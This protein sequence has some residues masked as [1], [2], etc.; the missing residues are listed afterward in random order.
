MLQ[1]TTTAT[2]LLLLLSIAH[3]LQQQQQQRGY[4]SRLASHLTSNDADANSRIDDSSRRKFFVS[5][6]SSSLALVLLTNSGAANAD[7]AG[8]VDRTTLLS[9]IAKNAPDDV[10]IDII[11]KLKDG[12]NNIPNL[13]GQWELI[14]SYKA[15][16]FS[17]LLK[18]PKPF[19]PDSYQYFGADDE[20]GPGRIA[21]GLTGGILGRDNQLWLS[22]GAAALADNP[23][24]LEILPPF[25]FQWGG[26][27]G[28]GVPKKTIAEAGSDADF[29]TVNGRTREAQL[30][31]KN[32][33][34]QLY[35]E[36]T[37]VGSL[38]VSS[39]TAGDPVLVGQIFVHRKL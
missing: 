18:L 17:P 10:V 24:V 7:N 38:R 22:S 25:R 32:L 12:N 5:T 19:K 29:R 15:E 16:T 33:Y 20:V 27:A 31:G 23:S 35:V 6:M 11:G 37:G 26:R 34:E 3:G 14:W 36:N 1:P 39:V 4:S 9:A 13:D 30:A 8:T 2:V 21:Q 28:S